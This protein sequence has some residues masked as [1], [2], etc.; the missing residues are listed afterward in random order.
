MNG[1]LQFEVKKMFLQQ[2]VQF[3]QSS[4]T[5]SHSNDQAESRCSALILRLQ[6]VDCDGSQTQRFDVKDETREN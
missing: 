4:S 1:K 3:L 6:M 2:R 5:L